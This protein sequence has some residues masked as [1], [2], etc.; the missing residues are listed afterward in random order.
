MVAWSIGT[1]LGCGGKTRVGAASALVLIMVLGGLSQWRIQQTETWWTKHFSA[2]KVLMAGVEPARC[3]H[4]KKEECL[5]DP[6]QPSDEC[7]NEDVL[8][9]K[10]F[11]FHAS[12]RQ[13]GPVR[14]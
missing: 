8:S 11:A 10:S 9:K 2:A 14:A 6:Y 7:P 1:G 3:C 12:W 13:S 4:P 5:L